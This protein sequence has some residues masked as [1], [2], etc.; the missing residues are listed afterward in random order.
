MDNLDK[1]IKDNKSNDK[2]S[3][4]VDNRVEATLDMI[5]KEDIEE[6]LQV[7]HNK[8]KRFNFR[9]L[10]IVAGL[11]LAI[12]VSLGAKYNVYAKVLDLLKS[13]EEKG[14]APEKID[15][16]SK[17]LD[18]NVKDNGYTVSIENIVSDAHTIRIFYN[19]N[20]D[21]TEDQKPG[22]WGNEMKID[23]KDLVNYGGISSE[24][25]LVQD[26]N[27]NWSGNM[28]VMRVGKELPKSFNFKWN[29]YN[30]SNNEGKWNFDIN[31]NSEELAKDTKTIDVN[32][33]DK[34]DKGDFN[35]KNITLSPIELDI[36]SKEDINDRENPNSYINYIVLD[37]NNKLLSLSSNYGV[38]RW[39]NGDNSSEVYYGYKLNGKIPSKIKIIPY[40]ILND[41]YNTV[42]GKNYAIGIKDVSLYKGEKGSLVIE[43]IKDKEDYVEVTVNIKGYL[44]GDLLDRLLL[45]KNESSNSKASNMNPESRKLINQNINSEEYVLKFNKYFGKDKN[46]HISFNVGN[47]DEYL[48]NIY[49]IYE[50]KAIE[51]DLN[52]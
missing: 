5:M 12:S 13:F 15:L 48:D 11:A 4:K 9:K 25:Y 24:E 20:S 18:K 44:R 38:N 46:Y 14:E 6:E 47:D 26:D 43:S 22:I 31:I 29:I 37:E 3:E 50:D 42:S 32:K 45:V 27:K 30:I 19:I 39:S 49:K 36:T 41:S 35:I 52:K 7:E 21:K 28:L 17:I 16:Y 23:D 51:V 8:K 2:I 33:G 10:S 1:L 40:K 34:L